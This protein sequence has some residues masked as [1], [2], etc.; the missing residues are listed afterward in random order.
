MDLAI[1][2]LDKQVQSCIEFKACYTFDI[3][4]NNQQN[5]RQHILDDYKKYVDV[6]N[7]YEVFLFCSVFVLEEAQI[8]YMMV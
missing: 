2:T 5:Y 1:L 3:I 7:S 6:Q 8:K 4:G